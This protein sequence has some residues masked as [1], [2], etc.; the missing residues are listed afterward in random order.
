MVSSYDFFET[1]LDYLGTRAK[2]YLQRIGRSYSALLRGRSP[3]WRDRL[4]FEYACV[5]C[6]RTETLKYIEQTNHWPSEMYDQ[7]KEPGETKILF[8]MRPMPYSGE[9]MSKD[10]QQFL[11]MQARRR[12]KSGGQP[13]SKL[14]PGRP[15]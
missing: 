12:L 1:I 8:S 13:R 10:L 15:S 6:I 4:Y 5:R 11:D 3:K 7:E 9:A 14:L 2:P